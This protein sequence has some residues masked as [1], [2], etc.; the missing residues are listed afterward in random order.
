MTRYIAR[1]LVQAIPILIAVSI[2]LFGLLHLVPGG[3][4]GAYAASAYVDP[5]ELDAI[6]RRLGLDDPI[7]VQYAKWL[8]GIVTGDWGSSYKYSRPVLNIVGERISP[9]LQL[10]GA[11]LLIALVLSVPLGLL[12]AVSSWRLVR[13]GSSVLSMLGISIPTFWLGMMILLFF[14]VKIQLIPSSG[15][16]TIGEDFS[17][18]DR[19][20]HLI[21]P[22]FVLATLEIAAW[23][24][25]VRSSVL[26][27]VG[28]DYVRTARAKGLTGRTVIV[29]HVMR[30]A[31]LPLITLIGLQGGRLLGGAL[32]T[33]VVFAW[34]GMGRLLTESLAAR[35]YPVLMAVFMLMS[36]LVIVGNLAADVGYAVADPRIRLN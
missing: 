3:P 36:V 24:R 19:I 9:S 17:V 23:S 10:V 34:P 12:S 33:E 21:A 11:S 26:D 2:I 16:S 8:R 31:L 29:R 35:D 22:A 28:E 6:E 27:I 1:R 5:A 15:M 25:Y 30:N 20:H 32:I 18:L 14:S 7:P 13:Y 4:M